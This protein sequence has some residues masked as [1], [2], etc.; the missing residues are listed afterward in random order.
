MEK[1]QKDLAE[2]AAQIFEEY[3]IDRSGALDKEEM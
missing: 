3:D 1:S 2:T